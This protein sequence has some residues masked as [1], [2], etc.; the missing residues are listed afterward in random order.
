VCAWQQKKYVMKH[1]IKPVL[2]VYNILAKLFMV[3]YGK[4]WREGGCLSGD[5]GSNVGVPQQKFY[6]CI[7]VE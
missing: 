3:K 5:N 6:F 4:C 7:T 2:V 1:N